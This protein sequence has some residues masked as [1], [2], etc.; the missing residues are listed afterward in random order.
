[1]QDNIQNPIQSLVIHDESSTMATTAPEGMTT[2]W[3]MRHRHL[4]QARIRHLH[5]A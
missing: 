5:N 4:D 2:L 1:M 3:K